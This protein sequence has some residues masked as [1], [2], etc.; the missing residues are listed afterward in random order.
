MIQKYILVLAHWT[1]NLIKKPTYFILT[2]IP[3]CN[4][5]ESFLSCGIPNLQLDGFPFEFNGPNFEVYADGRNVT[6]CVGVVGEPKQQ[7]RLSHARVTDQQELEQV[8]TA[9]E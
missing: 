1:N 3:G 2:F 8:V 5:S 6:L 9:K 7:A 4:G